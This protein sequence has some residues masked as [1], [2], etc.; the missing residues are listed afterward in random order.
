[1]MPYPDNFDGV[2]YQQAWGSGRSMASPSNSGAVHRASEKAMRD[3][4]TK[5]GDTI[6]ALSFPLGEPVLGYDIKGI[7]EAL[8]EFKPGEK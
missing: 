5:C 6:K 3:A 1:M 8:D 4:L 2:A 7:L